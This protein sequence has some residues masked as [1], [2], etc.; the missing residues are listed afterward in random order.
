MIK[1]IKAFFFKDGPSLNFENRN[2]YCL[3]KCLFSGEEK[4]KKINIV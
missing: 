1:K 2:L 4:K 3:K